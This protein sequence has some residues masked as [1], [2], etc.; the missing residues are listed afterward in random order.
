M[1]VLILICF[2]CATSFSANAQLIA[3]FTTTNGDTIGGCSPYLVTFKNLTTGASNNAIY[4]WDLGNNTSSDNINPIATFVDAKAYTITLTVSD[5]GKT[6][7][8]SLHIRVYNKP[9]VDF[10]V[11]KI[12]GCLPFTAT[13][14]S[15]SVANDGIIRNYFWDFGDGT[16]SSENISDTVFHTYTIVQKINARLVVTNSFGCQNSIQRLSTIEIIEPPSANFRTDKTVACKLSETIKFNPTISDDDSVNYFWDFGDSTTSIERTPTHKFYKT[17]N[18]DIKLTVN[19]TALTGCSSVSLQPALITVNDFHSDFTISSP[20]CTNTNTLLQ[21][22]NSTI[23]SNS[24]WNFSDDNYLNSYF[25]N[26]IYKNF[27]KAGNVSIRLINSF[28]ICRDTVVKNILINPAPLLQ[29][30]LITD[31]VICGVPYTA[32]FKDTTNTSV[33]WKWNFNLSDVNAVSTIQ[34][35]KYT[36]TTNGN[37]NITLTVTD[38][39][40][41]SASTSKILSIQKPSIS[42]SLLADN[43]NI[44]TQGCPGL[45]VKFFTSNPSIIS[46]YVWD[47]DDGSLSTSVQPQHDF[48]QTKNHTISLKYTTTAG[49]K[50]I[51][52]LPYAITVYQKP[53]AN[54]ATSTNAV[55]GNA[56]ILFS[57]N[58]TPTCNN[59]SWIF[60][61]NSSSGL[62]PTYK[63]FLHQF[64][65]TGNFNV[66]LIAYNGT[67]SDTIQKIISVK[68]LPLYTR[69]IKSVNTCDGTRGMVSLIHTSKN[70]TDCI[71]NF[72]D[73]TTQSIDPNQTFVNHEYKNSGTYRV[74]LTVTNNKCSASNALNVFVLLK[75]QPEI[76]SNKKEICSSDSLQI[77]LNNLTTNPFQPTNGYNIFKWQY[78]DGT[79][80]TGTVYSQMGDR[81]NTFITGLTKFKI[82]ENALRA[83]F[84]STYFGCNDTTSFVP[85]LVNGPII[86][87]KILNNNSCFKTAFNFIDTSSE[88]GGATIK[89]R[90]WDFGDNSGLI[91]SDNNSINHI[92]NNPGNYITTLKVIDS[93]GCYAVSSG[94]SAKVGGAKTSFNWSPNPPIPGGSTIFLNTSNSFNNNIQYLWRFSNDNYTDNTSSKIIYKYKNISADTVTLIA[95][96]TSSKCA[97]TTVHFISINKMSTS[98]TFTSNYIDKNNCPPLVY[99]AFGKP[100]N[101]GSVSWNFGDGS[102]AGNIINP[103]HTYNQTGIYKITFFGYIND[104]VDSSINYITIKGPHAILNANAYQKC[105][106][107][108]ITLTTSFTNAFS[109]IWD[110]N[111]GNVQQTFDTS[112]IHTYSKPGI[113]T[114]LV[115]LKDS[116]GCSSAFTLNTPILIDSLYATFKASANSICDSNLVNFT[117]YATNFA[118]TIINKPLQYKWFFGTSDNNTSNNK[119]AE[120]FFTSPGKYVI[121]LLVQSSTGCIVKAQDSITV[122]PYPVVDAGPDKHIFYGTSETFTPIVSDSNLVYSWT[123]SLYLNNDTILNPVCT[124]QDDQAYTFTATTLAGCS[125]SDKVNVFYLG[126]LNLPNA[127]SPNGDGINDTWKIKYLDNY[128]GATLDVFNRYGQKVFHSDGYSKEWDGNMNGNPLPMGTYYYV[129]DPKNTKP[130]ISGSI[131]II[132]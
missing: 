31:T 46:E 2:L 24:Q 47:F 71:W 82:G 128:P 125:R 101:T 10:I 42:I 34:S 116:A 114:P 62:S 39:V 51:V 103:S 20:L 9:S 22:N 118:D 112:I 84:N 90:V 123:P 86:G 106:P 21:N 107:A 38:T 104:I 16:T 41:C 43:G 60:G 40:G 120:Y 74:T 15:K 5:S 19:N 96:D 48:Y 36:F 129:V 65:D 87:F 53:Q 68:D 7:T 85:V 14:I 124:P 130:I 117:S 89:N 61:D 4:V 102:I 59:W 32:S 35:P 91:I 100:L 110:F 1:K 79:D 13:Y 77:I 28:G 64:T 88:I 6:S 57:D 70:A 54:F 113:Y 95:V 92:Y 27:A 45:T 11:D 50:G 80:F 115:V 30:F 122:N 63:N 12:K 76:S 97:D 78:D 26:N 111:D 121:T 56:A 81:K 98:F 99:Y 52:T 69:I 72:G 126:K 3:N 67:C 83:I 66:Q 132:K 94:I 73:S 127:F 58:S 33:K 109:Y 29:G 93:K 131:T 17:G 119:N 108:N 25:G 49:C 105:S 23:S 55:C 75:Q 37:Y 44:I 8:K 18:Y